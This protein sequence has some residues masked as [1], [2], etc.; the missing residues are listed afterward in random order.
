[1]R[2]PQAGAG[3]AQSRTRPAARRESTARGRDVCS[4]AVLPLDV[5]SVALIDDIA[6]TDEVRADDPFR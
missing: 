4:E 1:M 3:K 5:R 2:K 6:R